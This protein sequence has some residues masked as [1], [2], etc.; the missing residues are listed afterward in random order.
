MDDTSGVGVLD[1]AASVLGALEAGPATLAQLVSS[2]G[3]ARPTAHRLA[4]ALEHHRLV[5]R[6]MQGRFVLGPR[7]NER[8][9]A[10]GVKHMVL[11]TWRWQPQWQYV[12]RLLDEG[13]VGNCHYAELKFLGGFATDAGYKWRFVG[14]RANGVYA[15]ELQ[16]GEVW[17]EGRERPLEPGDHVMRTVV[18]Y[19]H[20]PSGHERFARQ[21][22][23]EGVQPRA[24]INPGAS[25][26]LAEIPDLVK[27]RLGVAA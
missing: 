6:D 3:L 13:Y 8:A 25:D 23:P 19:A 22:H 11:F 9:T 10:A 12:K 27:A 26:L 4:V 1:K 20:Q 2:T 24:L 18:T 16:G 5:A 17:A 14:R 15:S 21:L 7:L